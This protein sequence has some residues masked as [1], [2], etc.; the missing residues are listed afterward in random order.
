MNSE[1]CQQRPRAE[2]HFR[3]SQQQA[4]SPWRG[5]GRGPLCGSR[6]KKRES[7]ER[8]PQVAGPRHEKPGSHSKEGGLVLSAEASAQEGVT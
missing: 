2:P 8:S 1:G 5:R 6:A 3:Q 4:S 7:E